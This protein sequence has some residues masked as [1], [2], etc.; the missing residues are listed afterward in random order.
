MPSPR[1]LLQL[2]LGCFCALNGI[3][4][5][6]MD[7][8]SKSLRW[9]RWLAIYRVVHN[10]LVFSLSTMFLLDFWEQHAAE[11]KN[12]KLMTM[13]FFTYFALVFLAIIGS[14]ACCFLWQNRIFEVLQKLRHQREQSRQLGYRVPRGK[15]LFVDCLMFLAAIL[16]ILRLGIHVTMWLISIR[17]GFHHPCNCFLPECMIFAMNYLVFAILTE[18]CQCWWRLQSGLEMILLD[19]SEARTVA[20]QLSQIQKLHTMFQCLTDVTSEVC[21]I[22]KFVLLMYMARN[23]WS[24]IVAGYMAIRVVLGRDVD[25][26]LSYVVLAFIIC[27]QPLM[28]SVLMN[29][30]THATDLLLDATKDIL[31]TPHKQCARVERR[32]EWLSLQLAGQHT[33]IAVFGTFRMNRSL[34]FQ[35]TSVILVHV[36]YMVQSDYIALTK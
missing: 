26:E 12:S 30:M 28:F 7:S 5:F 20:S 11:I 33:Y 21:S 32:I 1:R 22:F 13:N 8:A 4:D 36:L 23:L 18:I 10:F 25:V 31:R 14:M 15:Q 6:Y 9:S 17:V 3:L 35:S 19:S 27:I 16:L 34:L 24:G 2:A 29:S